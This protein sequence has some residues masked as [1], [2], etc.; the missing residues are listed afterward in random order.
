MPTQEPVPGVKIGTTGNFLAIPVDAS[1]N[2]VPLEPGTIVPTWTASAAQIVLTQ[3]PDGLTVSAAVPASL[4][5]SQV[6]S[7]VLALQGTRIDG[8]NITGTVTVTVLPAD[9][10]AVPVNFVITQTS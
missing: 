6:P 10:I 9:V 8:T 2:A 7:F 5:I 1:G 4:D 3:S